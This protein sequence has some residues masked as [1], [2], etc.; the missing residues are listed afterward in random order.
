[1]KIIIILSMAIYIISC[2]SNPTVTVPYH[3]DRSILENT[4]PLSEDV[5]DGL[6]GVYR[7]TEGSDHFG[8]K[9]VI[10]WSQQY[11]SI[12]G[13]KNS[14]YFILEGGSIDNEI[15]FEGYWR[16]TT[17]TET[18]LVDL[19]ISEESGGDYLL[20]SG[21]SVQIKL[22]GMYGNDNNDPDRKVTLVFDR[23]FG[24]KVFEKKFWIL[25]HRGAGRTS[26]LLPASENT[27]EMISLAERYGANAIEIDVKL[28][29]DRIPF[30]YHDQTINLRLTQKSPIWGEIEDFTFP[31]LN[32]FITLI[33]GEK[34]PSLQQALQFVLEETELSLVW[35]DMKS[36]KNDMPEVI[37]I[38][39]EIMEQAEIM[40]RD[41]EIFLGLPTEDKINQFLGYPSYED[42]LSLNEFEIE[43]VRQTSSEFWGPRWTLGTQNSKVQTM[44]NEGRRVITWTMDEVLYP[45]AITH[46]RPLPAGREGCRVKRGRV[47]KQSDTSK[48]FE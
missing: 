34:I 33:N 15:F 17:N 8:D 35:L 26:D 27:L 25:A 31:Q 10:K 28:S 43:D 30:L 16:Y 13:Q 42:I 32:S 19:R 41:L 7:V 24:P 2:D 3:G 21:D 1:M 36:E 9:V 11:I 22:E 29:H 6:E 5:K 47:G 38:Q 46:P 12:F 4:V 14:G 48:E 23:T 37:P 40:G 44:H 39:Q 45:V 18:G 20:S